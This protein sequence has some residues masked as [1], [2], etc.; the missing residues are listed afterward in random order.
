MFRQQFMTIDPATKFGSRGDLDTQGNKL[1]NFQEL[2]IEDQDQVLEEQR[3]KDLGQSLP[4]CAEIV[5][6]KIGKLRLLDTLNFNPRGLSF[7][8]SKLCYPRGSPL[9]EDVY[10]STEGPSPR[11]IAT[12]TD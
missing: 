1:R 8:I 11:P 7:T 3:N 12:T 10:P 5:S 4:S 2:R 9:E 6:D